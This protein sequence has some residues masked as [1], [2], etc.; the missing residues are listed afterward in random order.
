[1]LNKKKISFLN[2]LLT[3]S[4]ITKASK[5]AGI[6]R[7][8]AYSYM[9]DEEF[10]EA[11]DNAKSECIADTVRFMQ[12]N[13]ALCNEALIDI[14]KDPKTSPQIKINAINTIYSTCG[15]MTELNDIDTKLNKIESFINEQVH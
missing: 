13:L 3:E 15:K 6:T 5:K 1:M 2:A 12:G 14:I 10:K 4:T 7:K 9:Q 11:L 8:T